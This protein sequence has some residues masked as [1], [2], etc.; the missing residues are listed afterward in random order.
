[1]FLASVVNGERNVKVWLVA[2][3]T[4]FASVILMSVSLIWWIDCPV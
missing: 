4:I 2:V 3:S 1:M